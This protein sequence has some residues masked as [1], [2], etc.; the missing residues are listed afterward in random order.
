[1]ITEDGCAVEF[2]ALLPPT[3]EAEIVHAAIPPGASVLELGAGAG[4]VIGV[5]LTSGEPGDK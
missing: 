3:N 4:R 1:M 2:Y 5:P